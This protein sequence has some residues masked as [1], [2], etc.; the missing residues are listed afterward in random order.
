MLA[1]RFSQQDQSGFANATLLHIADGGRVPHYVCSLMEFV[2]GNG[3]YWQ[4]LLDARIN[5]ITIYIHNTHVNTLPNCE[6]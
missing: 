2:D 3:S 1:P 6:Y 4:L 5:G